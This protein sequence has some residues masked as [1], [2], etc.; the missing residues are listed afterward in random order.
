MKKLVV[1]C[2]ESRSGGARAPHQAFYGSSMKVVFR[3]GVFLDSAYWIFLMSELGVQMGDAVSADIYGGTTVAATFPFTD[4]ELA[5]EL[6]SK[7]LVSVRIGVADDS[8]NVIY[9]GLVDVLGGIDAG[10]LVPSGS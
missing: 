1:Y 10:T 3:D 9:S 5:V 8:G 6:E 4:G 7:K 2:D